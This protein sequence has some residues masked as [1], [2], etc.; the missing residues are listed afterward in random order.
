ML[1]RSSPVTGAGAGPEG[2]RRNSLVHPRSGSAPPPAGRATGSRCP[3]PGRTPAPGSSVPV[4]GCRRPSVRR[5]APRGTAIRSGSRPPAAAAGRPARRRAC[6]V[7]HAGP[8]RSGSLRRTRSV[9]ERL[10]RK[11]LLPGEHLTLRAGS[12]VLPATSSTPRRSCGGCGGRR[13]GPNAPSRNRRPRARG[14]RRG[15]RSPR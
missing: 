11:C 6:P 8:R 9:Q 5:A 4:C 14:R 2:R 1:R 3:L 13:A 7:V 12:T 10:C 15:R